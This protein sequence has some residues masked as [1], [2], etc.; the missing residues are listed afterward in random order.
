MSSIDGKG[1]DLADLV[2]YVGPFLLPYPFR[3]LK[4]E[5]RNDAGR[6][7][8]EAKV[9]DNWDLVRFW[10]NRVCLINKADMLR[11]EVTTLSDI[12]HG[13]GAARAALFLSCISHLAFNVIAAQAAISPS[14][15]LTFSVL[16]PYVLA[17]WL[18]R[19]FERTRTSALN[20]LLS[21]LVLTF[22]TFPVRVA[23]VVIEQAVVSNI[24]T[25]NAEV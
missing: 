6:K 19:V 16:A 22:K 24:N 13:V 18:F 10:L 25:S 12:Y 23:G 5:F 9:H 17:L 14:W 3:R 1:P 2:E 7:R 8:F 20:S 15:R 21:I 4:R 11:A